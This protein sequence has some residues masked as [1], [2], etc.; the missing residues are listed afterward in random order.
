MCNGKFRSALT[1]LS[2]GIN[3]NLDGSSP[4]AWPAFLGPAKARHYCT[5]LYFSCVW[6]P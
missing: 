6:I 4:G 1:R 2:R 3:Q 5:L